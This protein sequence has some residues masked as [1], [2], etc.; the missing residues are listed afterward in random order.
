MTIYTS[1][2]TSLFIWLRFGDLPVLPIR[3][4]RSAPRFWPEAAKFPYIEELAPPGWVFAVA[5]TDPARADR[6]YRRSLHILGV[7]RVKALIEKAVGDDPRPPALCCFESD[8]SECHRGPTGFASVW[9]RWTGE[10]VKDLALMQS[11]QGG[12]ALVSEM[13]G[14]P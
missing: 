8:P 12:C 2:W 5:R 13:G 11:L 10:Q 7:D 14:S 4:S 1:S 3:I 6:G 9:E